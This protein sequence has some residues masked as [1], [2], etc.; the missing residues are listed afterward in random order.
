MSLRITLVRHGETTG[1]SSIRYYGATD[2]ALSAHGEEQMRRVGTALAAHRFDRVFTSEL[3]RSRRAAALIRAEE[4]AATPVP[5][6]NE[7]DFG[8]WEGWTRDEIAAR[9]PEHFAHWQRDG[10][11][12]TYP[13]GESRVAFRQRVVTGLGGFLQPPPQGAWLMVLH[14]GVI[15]VILTQLLELSPQRRGDLAIDLASIH[16]VVCRAGHWEAEAVDLVDHL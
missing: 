10:E 16:H 15:A 1:Q 2:V 8:R 12:F 3:Q 4:G 14:R 11:S 9:D 13:G 7:V 6:F 5:S